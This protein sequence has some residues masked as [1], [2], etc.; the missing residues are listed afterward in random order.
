MGGK[1]SK[2]TQTVSIPPEVLARYN[3]VNARAEQA[4]GTPFQPYSYNP[5]DF[6]AQ[7]T[8]TQLAAIQNINY[9]AGQAQP[10]YD[11]ATNQLMGAQMGAVPYYAQAGQDIGVG[12]QMGQGFQQQ[13]LQALY[14]AQAGAAPLNYRAGT[15]Y[16]QAYAQGQPYIGAGVGQFAQGQAQAQPYQQAAGQ[17][18]AAAQGIGA[19]LAQQAYAQQ[20]GAGAMAMPINQRAY[21]DLA[22][23]YGS[24]QPLN[25]AA[26][27]QYYSGLAAAQPLQQ[28]ALGTLGRAGGIGEQI[29]GQAL[30]SLAQAGAATTPLQY[31]GLDLARQ[32]YAATQPMNQAVMQQYYG[33]L[34]A[35]QPLQQYA[36]GT[37]GRAGETGEAIAGRALS[38]LEAT[39]AGVTPLQ[40]QG[41]DLVRQ[42]LAGAQPLQQQALSTLGRAGG[43]GEQVAGQALG[44]LGEGL[45][46]ARPVQLE[47]LARADQ[48]YGAAQPYTGRADVAYQR[49]LGRAE[50]LQQYALGTL[51]QGQD[52]S[53]AL[54][55]QALA[56]L[57]RGELRAEPLQQLAQGIYGQAYQAAQP[58]TQAALEQYYG[59]LG[60]AGPIQ[61]AALAQIGAAPGMAAPLTE[62]AAQ[63]IAAAQAGASPYQRYAT[64]L[65]LA[66]ARPVTPG[67]LTGREIQQYMSPY[68][69]NVV[70]QTQALLNQQANQ[71]QAEQLGNAIR[72]GAFGGDRSRI[73]AANLQQQQQLAQGKVLSDLLQSGYGQALGT[74]Q[75]Q[76]QLAL[77]AE[78]ANRAA[79]QAAAGQLL[80]VG[81]A[82]FGQGMTAAQ[83]QAALAQQLYGQ[84]LGTGQAQA[85]LAQQLFG[86]QAA[87]GQNIAGLGQQAFGQGLATGQAQQALAQQLFGQGATTSAQQQAIA[88]SLFGRGATSAAQQAALAQQTFGQ[89]QAVAQ[90]LAALGQQQFGQGMANLAAREATAQNLFGQSA[91]AAQQQAA[92]AQQLFGQGATQAAQQ[93]ALAQQEFGQGLAAAQQQQAVAQALFGQGAT[94]AQQQAAIAQQLFG[95]GA[96]QAQQ[97]AALAQQAFG[98]NLATGQNI[99]ALTQQMFGQGMGTAQQQQA[100][101]QALFGQG[102]TTAQQQAAIAQNLFGQGATQAAQQAA[103]AQQAF[104]QNLAAGQNMAQMAQQLYGQGTGTAQ[105][106]AAI[107]QQAFQQ[108][109]QQAQQQQALS[110]LLYGQGMGA[111][112]QQ[113]ALG[114]QIFGQG[115]AGSQQLGALGQQGFAQQL[116]AAQ[117]RQGLGQGLYGMGAG[118]AQQ[119]AA[120]GAGAQGAALQGAQ[121]QLAAG[122]AQQ[123]T[124]QAGLQALYNQFLQQQAYPF[125][126]AQF[127]GNIAMGTG[128]LSGSTTTTVQPGSLFSDIRTKENVRKVGETF[129]K[130]PIYSFNYKGDPKTQMGLIAQEV[131]RKHPEAVGLAGG[132]KTVDYE[133]ATRN[134]ARRGEVIDAEFS[135]ISEGGSVTPSRAGLGF[136]DGGMPSPVA[137]DAQKKAEEEMRRKQEEE[138]NRRER[139]QAAQISQAMQV[140]KNSGSSSA[141]Q[142][143]LK[144]DLAAQKSSQTST[145]APSKL[146]IPMDSRPLP[147]L[148]VA[149]A[150]PA[151]GDPAAQDAATI[152]SLI[153]SAVAFFSDRR[154]KEDIKHIGNTYDGQKIYS[155]RIKGDPHTQIGLMADEVEEHAPDAVGSVNGFKTVDYDRATEIAAKAGRRHLA[156][157]GSPGLASP[158]DMAALLAAQ[159]QMFGPFSQYAMPN[160][161]VPGM[162]SYVPGANLPVG[163]LITAGDLPSQSSSLE[164]LKSLY[165]IGK[166]IYDIKNPPKTKPTT[167]TPST[168]TETPGATPTENPVDKAQREFEEAKRYRGGL[169]YADGGQV[170]PYATPTSLNIPTEMKT[171][172]LMKA[173]QLPKQRSTMDD[174]KDILGIASETKDLYDKFN[175][176]KKAHGGLAGRHAYQ[177]G[178]GDQ[179]ILSNVFGTLFDDKKAKPYTGIAPVDRAIEAAMQREGTDTRSFR[180]RG[181]SGSFDDAVATVRPR[182]PS[183]PRVVSDTSSS[184]APVGGLSPPSA[185]AAPAA[186]VP[187]GAVTSPP[188]DV[189]PPPAPA[190]GLAPPQPA[191]AA[192]TP[193]PA[194]AGPAPGKEPPKT[195]EGFMDWLKKPENY[196]PLLQGAAAAATAP[197]QYTLPALL[198]GASAYGKS[199]QDVRQRLADIKS[200][201]AATKQT[202]AATA[203]INAE[204]AELYRKNQV[205]KEADGREFVILGDGTRMLLGKWLMLSPSQ[206]AQIPLMGQQ[207]MAGLI[208]GQPVAPPALGVP[209]ETAPGAPAET[210]AQKAEK[211]MTQ[212]PVGGQ[213]KYLTPEGEQQLKIDQGALQSASGTLRS[214]VIEDNRANL[215]RVN[216]A[217][218][219]A[220][221]TGANLSQMYSA[222]S[223]VPETGI[224]SGGAL[225]KFKE[226]F[227][228]TVNDVIRTIGGT[229]GASREDLSPFMFNE[230]QIA[231]GTAMRKI[232]AF[233]SFAMSKGASQN[234]LG[235]LQEAASAVPSMEM[236]RAD[237][238]KI[239]ASL[240]IEK[241]RALDLAN[242]IREAR[243]RAAES[244]MPENIDIGNMISAFR[245]SSTWNDSAYLKKKD[246]VLALMQ[247]KNAAGVSQ[248]SW[249]QKS[250]E[251]PEV[252]DQMAADL[253]Y[254][255]KR[256]ANGKIIGRNSGPIRGI[257]NILRNN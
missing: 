132:L 123:Q 22:A 168:T 71:A 109:M 77:G 153:S 14:G 19:Q 143:D 200:T 188:A 213:F 126:V 124:A 95:Q 191:P 110:Q 56:S 104:G 186:N 136:A 202:E 43:I 229:F 75:Q 83:Q 201:E 46:A 17:N 249:L 51:G 197:T 190:G 45:G 78:Q 49:G 61:Q 231:D 240:Y 29:S 129:D 228:K 196:I 28:Y 243:A 173:G 140:A 52:I 96:T 40:L 106:Q 237:A 220:Y 144:P 239:L 181:A 158:T 89:N 185:N 59:G 98:Q 160:S 222:L 203:Q 178:G 247:K 215:A 66:A 69:S 6:V 212:A 214:G 166:D 162:P 44:T 251:D 182:T 218:D 112:Q 138:E 211:M 72:S 161:G 99:A 10:Y 3:A 252:I 232:S 82:G 145:S 119:L 246:A 97:Q 175:P 120:L 85:A 207:E 253:V 67:A 137:D 55:G 250:S 226:P 25:Q 154:L 74:A 108:Q 127:L 172:E 48:V 180:G 4:A 230:Q 92:I 148:A 68:M 70:G 107:G 156:D 159:A 217:A 139:S 54:S 20:A 199:Y 165:G 115:L 31:E 208:S 13:A 76:Q 116:A 238:E 42:S 27:Q 152:A 80:G 255:V 163:Q 33:G 134:A 1:T 245:R 39:G 117:A 35:A 194:A 256:D 198:V 141:P 111:A 2:S 90:G 32:A 209:A 206:R 174:V 34:A 84:Q 21:A 131:E 15:A 184:G 114:Q 58:F 155:Y 122:Q 225:D 242:Y 26:V 41:L 65:G 179:S 133:R 60:I 241:Q 23:A 195:K 204:R 221:N 88:E 79:Q 101:A 147:Q 236:S 86:Q 53:Q 18:I 16:E 128:A 38:G 210:P 169:A 62:A 146:D 81:Q 63:N 170:I 257:S 57:G 187:A 125:Q 7:L 233:L 50:D 183:P 103:L 150:A 216:E 5:A 105:A 176:E 64:E 193:A 234:S 224:L 189:A 94:T 167:P 142:V 36:L 102:A 87:A 11:E 235:A 244:G 130:Q 223:G 47:N 91:Q 121:A 205:V 8:P 157:G 135:P 100:V 24:A 73:A 192:V 113:A 227:V 9:A 177:A 248:W 219:V 254:G 118:T 164:D 12:Q 171:P 149:G 37:L 93:A 30:G 151:G